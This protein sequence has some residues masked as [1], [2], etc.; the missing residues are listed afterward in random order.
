MANS[1]TG[2]LDFFLLVE[3][4][5]NNKEKATKYDEFL[6]KTNSGEEVLDTEGQKWL[7]FHPEMKDWVDSHEEMVE[8]MTE[9]VKFAPR[10]DC[11]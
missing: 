10:S 2:L 11:G 9:E 4:K 1:T 5:M 7:L 6:A 3:Q 8:W